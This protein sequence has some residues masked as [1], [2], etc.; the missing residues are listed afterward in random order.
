[1]NIFYSECLWLFF[2]WTDMQC[3]TTLTVRCK[4]NTN[5]HQHINKKKQ[6]KL[7]ANVQSTHIGNGWKTMLFV[8][9]FNCHLG[10]WSRSP[11]LIWLHKGE[12]W[13][14]SCDNVQVN[15]NIKVCAF[16][17]SLICVCVKVTQWT[18]T[19]LAKN[20]TDHINSFFFFSC[21]NITVTLKLWQT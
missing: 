19:K 16:V 15:T 14:A 13:L 10:N 20:R 11:K 12:Q 3:W 4:K 1:M 5:T 6:A 9:T 8:Q 17:D 2:C 21:S 7:N 18:T